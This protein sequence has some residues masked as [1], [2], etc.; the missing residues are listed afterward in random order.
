MMSY[1]A[2]KKSYK[3]LYPFRLGTTS[4]IY[5]ADYIPNIKMLGPYLD[6]IEL[7]LF[8]SLPPQSLPTKAVI[9][10][11]CQIGGEH[12]LRYN[13]HLPIDVSISHSDPKKQQQAV[14]TLLAVINL[15]RPL[16]P[17]TCTLHIPYY[18]NSYIRNHLNKWQ[19][20]VQ[21]NLIK[22]LESGAQPELIAIETLDYPFNLLEPIIENLNLSVCLD[23]GHLMAGAYDMKTVFNAYGHN[24]VI[25]HLHAF[26]KNRDHMALNHLSP[27]HAQTI[28]W[29]LNNF[30]KTVSI[31]VFSFEDLQASLDYLDQFCH[32]DNRQ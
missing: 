2:L 5:P 13:I 15:V 1:P 17:T 32:I 28:F 22:I 21:R 27:K 8:E 11:L 14:D 4:Y 29:I 3:G 6:E 9:D 19:K 23:L 18:Q 25:I 10:E 31:E 16:S 20:R 24:T 7:L 30:Q 26:A 12:D